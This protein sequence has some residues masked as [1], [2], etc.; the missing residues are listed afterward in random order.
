MQPRSSPARFSVTNV[1]A[2]CAS[3]AWLASAIE[4]DAELRADRRARD[5]QQ[6]A[7]EIS[8]GH[9]EALRLGPSVPGHPAKANDA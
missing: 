7:A 4:R 5:R 6:H 3:A 9:V 2:G 1:A 8:V